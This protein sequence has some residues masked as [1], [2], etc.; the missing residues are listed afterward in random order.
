MKGHDS[1][2][3]VL[4]PSI[5]LGTWG[6]LVLLTALTITVARMDLGVM[7]LVVAIGIAALKAS[8]VALF[9]M[10]LAY[11]NKFQV[12]V[13][14]GSLV[15]AVLLAGFVVFDTTHYQS[16]IRAHEAAAKTKATRK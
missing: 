1:S 10:H 5:L 3:H 12:V 11:E 15:F 7:N 9:F 8:I 6:A 13:L 14:V 2:A 16:T 4:S